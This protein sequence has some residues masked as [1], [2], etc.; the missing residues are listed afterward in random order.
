[1]VLDGRLDCRQVTGDPP[2][3]CTDASPHLEQV[4]QPAARPHGSKSLRGRTADCSFCDGSAMRRLKAVALLG[5]LVR[6]THQS[7]VRCGQ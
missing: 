3:A 6:L 4:P 1:M 2:N 5:C 7:A